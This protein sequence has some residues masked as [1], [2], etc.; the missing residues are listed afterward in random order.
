M[1]KVSLQ[2]HT[3][4]FWECASCEE[5]NDVEQITAIVICKNSLCKKEYLVNE[6]TDSM[7]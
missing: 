7:L 5:F 4:Y 1:E 3:P 6:I 2:K